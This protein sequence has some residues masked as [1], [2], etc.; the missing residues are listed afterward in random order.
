MKKMFVM[1]MALAL[2][3]AATACSP[4]E[5]GNNGTSGRP[6]TSGGDQWATTIDLGEV[7]TFDIAVDSTSLTETENIDLDDEDY[8][9]NNEFTQTI[10][11]TW[12]G[13]AVSV[14]G[15]VTGVS[16]ETDGGHVTVVSTIKGVNYVLKGTTDNGSFKIYGEKKFQ[17]TLNGV[18]ITNPTGAAV[19]SQCKK[20]C[21]VVLA[22]GTYNQFAD[23]SDYAFTDDE[24]M[25]GAL[26]AEGKLLFSG[27]GHLKVTAYY[28]FG[29]C[30]DDY[31]LFRPGVNIY[32]NATA[33]SAI[34]ANDAILMRGGVVNV[35]CSAAA[36]KGMKCDGFVQVDGGR[37]TALTTGA[38]E[39]DSDEQDVKASAG[40]KA[41]S[42]I[43]ING[44]TVLA[45]STGRG[46]KGLSSD[47]H[48]V[49]NG[50]TVKL[51]TTNMQ[52]TYNN[53]YTAKSKGIKADGDLTINGGSV[54]AR[55]TGGEGSEAIESKA[56]LTINNGTVEVY[57]YDDA[58]NSAGNMTI[59]GG[60]IF[61]YSTNNDGID[62]NGTLTVSGGTV[63][64]CGTTQPED[65]FDSDQNAFIITGGTV[66]GLGGGTSVPSTNG[67]TQPV[68]VLGGTN[69]NAG[70]LLTVSGNGVLAFTV[71][72]SYNSYTL[73]VS[74]PIL[75]KGGTCSIAT[76]ANASGSGSSFH[77]LATATG[78]SGGNTIFNATLSSIVT[79]SNYSGGMGGG[80]W[81]RW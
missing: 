34:K 3:T 67:T 58:I 61:A 23:G 40:I 10:G 29:I 42:L 53:R 12:N 76:G 25:K 63:I 60:Q 57:A 77:G 18:S 68:V 16:V 13:D 48:V 71:P 46:G 28:K 72:R 30:S 70:T 37:F 11:I 81:G 32:V 64:S 59:A 5:P 80:G 66:V 36:A 41:D 51:I 8:V 21:Y 50:G 39:W 74:S 17:L 78:V 79:T 69:I 6:E 20:R 52:Y 45:K 49:I 15:T 55:T 47:Q 62:T 44:G 26:F 1:L 43:T 14:N 35:E 31:I 19:N 56:R 9:E 33:G 38:G 75:S 22:D 65:G 4:D 27:S 7:R 73:L 54:M 24:D 2:L